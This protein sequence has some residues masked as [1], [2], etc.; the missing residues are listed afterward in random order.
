[1][2]PLGC[3]AAPKPENALYPG[4]R[5]VRIHD[6]CASDKSNLP[7]H[8]FPSIRLQDGQKAEQ[9]AARYFYLVCVID[10]AS[11]IARELKVATC[12]V[13][14]LSY[15]LFNFHQLLRA[16]IVAF[17]ALL[18][19]RPTHDGFDLLISTLRKFNYKHLKGG[20]FVKGF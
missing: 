13:N 8:R 14:G 19:C 18:L 10:G 12:F 6:C 2:L 11:S 20:V 1:L 16:Q 17:P 15:Q 7:R 3:G 4:N 9:V 5:V